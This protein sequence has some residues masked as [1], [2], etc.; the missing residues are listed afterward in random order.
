MMPYI[1]LILP[2]YMVMAV[3]GIIVC[4][5]YLNNRREKYNISFNRLFVLE[6]VSIVGVVIGSKLVFFITQLP[7]LEEYSIEVMVSRFLSGGYV[8]YGGVYGMIFTLF[9]S[10]PIV[11]IKRGDLMQFVT[12]AIPLFHCFGRVGCFMSGCCHGLILK[13]PVTVGGVTFIAFPL[14]LIGAALDFV[15][16]LVLLWIEKKGKQRYSLLFYYLLLYSIGRFIYEFFR[17]DTVRGIWF[18]LSTSQWISVFTWI[19]IGIYLWKNKG[20]SR[21][22]SMEEV[23]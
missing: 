14:Q 23:A 10:A 9:L 13:H 16:F 22:V 17:G 18:F 2:S 1:Y 5:L 6:F 15:L 7:I 21:R 12:P 4:M 19:G 3:M 8:F 20:R 11:K